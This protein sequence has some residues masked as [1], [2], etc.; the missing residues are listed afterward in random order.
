MAIV[1][2]ILPATDGFETIRR[3]S[4]LGVQS[5]FVISRHHD[6]RSV[7]KCLEMGADDYLR[8]P[9]ALPIFLAKIRTLLRRS[10]QAWVE[11]PE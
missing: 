2:F 1:D 10:Y 11:S 4:E 8:K 7:V 9:F 6:E 5:I 3:L